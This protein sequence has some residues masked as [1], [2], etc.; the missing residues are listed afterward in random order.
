MHRQLLIESLRGHL[1]LLKKKYPRRWAAPPKDHERPVEDISLL[2]LV[3]KLAATNQVYY[4]HPSFGYYFE[5]LY[6][7]PHGLVNRLKACPTDSLIL[8]PVPKEVIEENE[9]FWGKTEEEVL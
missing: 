6:P 9:K 2:Q 7:E 8:P 4:L 1:A 5:L 3:T